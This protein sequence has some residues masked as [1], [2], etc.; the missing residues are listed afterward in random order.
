MTNVNP[1]AIFGSDIVHLLRSNQPDRAP[2]TYPATS[3]QKSTIKSSKFQSY[4]L[5]HD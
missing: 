3:F 2:H 4:A 5:M 1:L